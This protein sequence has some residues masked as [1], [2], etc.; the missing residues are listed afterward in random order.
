MT[1]AIT[2]TWIALAVVGTLWLC[3]DPTGG[4]AKPE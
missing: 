3:R 1:D 4:A 2:I